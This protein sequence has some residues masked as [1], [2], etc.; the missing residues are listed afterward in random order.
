MRTLLPA[1]DVQAGDTSGDTGDEKASKSR[2]MAI[3]VVA[4]RLRR[5][6]CGNLCLARAVPGS[7]SSAQLASGST[8]FQQEK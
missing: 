3:I 1:R 6:R 4:W 7:G 2:G 5:S 8:D